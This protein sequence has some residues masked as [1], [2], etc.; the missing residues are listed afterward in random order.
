MGEY[1]KGD[2][3]EDGAMVTQKQARTRRDIIMAM[4][5]LLSEQKFEVITINEIW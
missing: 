2:G 5:R 4:E 1:N 3:M